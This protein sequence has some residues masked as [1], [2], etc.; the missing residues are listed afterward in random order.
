MRFFDAFDRQIC[1][2]T[3][4]KDELLQVTNHYCALKEEVQ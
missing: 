4:G 2:A 1:D 3:I